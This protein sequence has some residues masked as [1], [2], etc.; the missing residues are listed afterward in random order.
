MPFPFR[1]QSR[2]VAGFTPK[3]SA[4]SFTLIQRSSM[5]STMMSAPF[6]GFIKIYAR[7]ISTS[8][9][10][11]VCLY[12]TID[13]LSSSRFLSCLVW[14]VA[15]FISLL[16]KPM[17]H[18]APMETILPFRF[19]FFTFLCILDT[20]QLPVR[21]KRNQLNIVIFLRG[22]TCLLLFVVC[23]HPRIDG[24][25]FS[26]YLPVLHQ[27][28][29]RQFFNLLDFLHLHQTSLLSTL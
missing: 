7:W 17:R 18:I 12:Y 5:F 28:H 4:T 23:R 13:Q 29:R 19:G 8:H 3:Y 25:P 2:I 14:F 16:S 6:I 10:A 20:R 22:Q 15:V 24:N 11:F 1:I 21:I 9:R 26:L 27:R